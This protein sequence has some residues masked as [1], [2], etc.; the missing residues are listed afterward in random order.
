MSYKI[1][2]KPSKKQWRA[3]ELLTDNETTQIGYGG[4]A[5]SGK[6]YL[7]CYWLTT[8]SLAYPDTG[9]G[10]CRKELKTLRRT[11]F[12]TL[13]KVFAESGLR[14]KEHYTYNAQDH[15]VT[16]YN[17]SQIFL[18]DMA[19]QPSDPLYTRFGGFELTGAA[20]DESNESEYRAIEILFSRCGWRNNKKYGLKK[21]LLETFNPDKGHVYR[22]YYKPFRDR[23]EADYKKFIPALPADNPAPEVKE[24]IDDFI[25]TADEI[26]VQR[27]IYGNFD[28]DDDPSAL[29]QYDAIQDCFTNTFVEHGDHCVSADLAMQ[30]RDLFIIGNWSGL[31]VNFPI[32][33]G[34]SG[35]KEIE[36]DL[37]EQCE[38]NSVP[39]SRTVADSDGLGNYL[40]DYVDGINTFHGGSRANNPQVYKNLRH[41]CFFKLAELIND[42]KIYIHTTDSLEK[43]RIAEELGQVKRIN[44]DNPDQPKQVIKKDTMKENIG[45]SP[46]YLDV[47]MMRMVFIL[48]PESESG[49]LNSLFGR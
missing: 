27:L 5:R 47:L 16:F 40:A 12:S 6:T 2:F 32:V 49:T 25:K 11:T 44:M 23:E 4:S 13:M 43:D 26:S 30:G 18:V 46:D 19:F 9:W 45:R 37:K 28:Y 33:K 1:D 7:Q 48:V 15:I 17:K 24:W 8:M 38:L 10:L 42:R 35:A 29:I 36:L 21:K 22:R 3:W 14:P 34:K 20:V 31:R 39:R 41:E